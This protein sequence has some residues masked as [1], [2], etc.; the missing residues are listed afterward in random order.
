MQIRSIPSKINPT[1]RQQVIKGEEQIAQNCDVDF[2]EILD[3]IIGEEYL[4]KIT[5]CDDLSTV[6]LLQIRVNTTTQSIHEITEYLPNLKSLILDTSLISTVRDLGVGFKSL[7]NLCLNDCG[8]TDLDGI[9]ALYGLETLSV[10]DNDISDVAPLA[11]QEN[12]QV[13]GLISEEK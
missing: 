1:P 4:Q 2:Q 3:G 13:G 9:G 7:V 11:M 5:Q 10:A 12:L 6:L 8:L